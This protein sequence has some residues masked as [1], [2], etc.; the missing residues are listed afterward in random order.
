MLSRLI[1]FCLNNQ[2]LVIIL[3]LLVA[4][5]GIYSAATIPIDAVPDMTN[6]QVQVITEAGSL[7]PLEVERY[8]TYPVETTMGGL[9]DIEEMRS[10]SKLGLSV[11][12]I[13]FHEGTDI[14]HARN[15]VQERLAEAKT[16]VGDYGN[17]QIGALS[18]A[19]GEILQFE[20]RGSTLFADGAAH[21]SRMGDRTPLA[22]H[23]GRDG[24][25]LA[26][27]ILQDV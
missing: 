10:V 19:L 20:V 24:S 11:V 12:T 16:A 8:I 27:R 3:V 25:Q 7:S 13:V 26:R 1:H 15:L 4:I 22:R 14:Y 17:P 18:T 23:A 5:A 9:P 2:L 21:N 6:V